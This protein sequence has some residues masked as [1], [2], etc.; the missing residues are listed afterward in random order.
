VPRGAGAVLPAVVDADQH[1]FEPPTMWQEHIDPAFRDRA[2]SLDVDER[3]YAWLAWQGRHLYLAE[4]QQPAC[5]E[6]IAEHRRRL[7]GGEAAADPYGGPI[8]PSFSEPAARL[9]ELDRWG[10][11]GAVLFPNFALL[12]E[13][14]LADDLPALCANMQATNRWQ[15]ELAVDGRG[16]LFG[17]GLLTLRD[18]QWAIAEITRLGAAGVRLAMVAPA[19]VNGR[20]L[21]DRSLDAVWAAFCDANVA[22]VFHVANVERPFDQAWYQNDPEPV[23]SLLG[24]VFL[25]VGAAVA[26]AD[27]ILNGT[28]ERFPDLRIGVVELSANWVPQFL[29]HLD[30]ATDFYRARHGDVPYPLAERPSH[31]FRRQVR[32]SVLAYERPAYLVSR[33]GDELFMFGSDWP[34]AEGIARPRADYELAIDQLSGTPRDNLM[35]ANARWLLGF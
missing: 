4:S 14:M 21:S 18:P 8:P 2:L 23:D 13:R 15:Q 11:D 33:T 20:P 7:A 3:G 27:L 17:V 29:L 28:L 34:H 12:W 35:G 26:L 10:V 1:R 6:T 24:S 22:P 31:Y 25:W 9:A 5:P 30:G 16:R 19:P 32:V